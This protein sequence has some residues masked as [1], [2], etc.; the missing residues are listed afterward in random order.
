MYL[1]IFKIWDFFQL[2]G[3]LLFSHE[4]NIYRKHP[5]RLICVLLRL[6]HTPHST[7]NLGW[8]PGGGGGGRGGGPPPRKGNCS[9]SYYISLKRIL[10]DELCF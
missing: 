8:G 9:V 10:T 1:Y 5:H 3:L 6:T 2:W 7:E 4:P